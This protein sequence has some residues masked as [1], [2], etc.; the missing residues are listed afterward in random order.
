MPSRD[1]LALLGQP[2]LRRSDPPAELWQYRGTGCVLE[3]YLY[4]E[5]DI[6]RVVHAETHGRS[7]TSGEGCPAV[8]NLSP[9][10]PAPTGLRQSR[11]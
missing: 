3:L 8:G 9:A 7:L 6:F 11:L 4:R 1:L 2:D 5:G 10:A